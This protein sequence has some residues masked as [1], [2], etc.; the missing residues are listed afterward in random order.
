MGCEQGVFQTFLTQP[1]LVNVCHAVE[2]L[3]IYGFATVRRAYGL[4]ALDLDKIHVR[5]E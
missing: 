2:R 1:P 4:V 5:R 3:S